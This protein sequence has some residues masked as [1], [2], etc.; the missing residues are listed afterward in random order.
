MSG[1]VETIAGVPA[2][3][4]EILRR[5]KRAYHGTFDSE[6]GL[7]VL[8]DL[9]IFC[10]ANESCFHPDPRLHAVLEGR[11]EVW[12]RITNRLNLST[13]ELYAILRRNKE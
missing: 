2:R 8:K 12:V 1:I 4:F 13:E 6:C 9:A 7:D 3:V 11:R 5:E 10:R